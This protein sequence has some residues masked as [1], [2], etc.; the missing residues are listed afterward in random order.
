M[1]P[2][3]T[4]H[5]PYTGPFKNFCFMTGNIFTPAQDV[6]WQMQCVKAEAWSRHTIT[7]EDPADETE[8]V[9]SFWAR[10]MQEKSTAWSWPGQAE[11][12][13]YGSAFEVGHKGGGKDPDLTSARLGKR[14]R[15]RTQV[16]HVD[17]CAGQ[18]VGA[19]ERGVVACGA[20]LE[21]I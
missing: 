4:P 20:T 11:Q 17:L 10:M 18:H 15:N 19:A 5:A 3:G 14:T 12:E 9:L 21:T 1:Q 2:A 6:T 7:N 16:A 8:H 13:I